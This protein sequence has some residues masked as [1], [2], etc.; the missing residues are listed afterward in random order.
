MKREVPEVALFFSFFFWSKEREFKENSY[1]PHLLCP[2][3]LLRSFCAP[4]P[5]PPV[6]VIVPK[7]F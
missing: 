4:P 6:S 2:L 1:H 5:P 7:H 3:P